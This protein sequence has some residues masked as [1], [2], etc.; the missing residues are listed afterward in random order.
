MWFHGYEEDYHVFPPKASEHYVG[1]LRDAIGN[2]HFVNLLNLYQGSA[3]SIVIDITASM[4]E[5]LNTVKE[6]A[7]LIV[8]N[9]HP[10][11]F[12]FVPYGDPGKQ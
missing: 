12:V 5:E 7:K 9:S 10:E 11:L 2:D 8:M 4:S 1:V 6:E 3:L